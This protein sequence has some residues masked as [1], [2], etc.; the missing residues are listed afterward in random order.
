VNEST[1]KRIFPEILHQNGIKKIWIKL[2]TG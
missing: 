1:H 2:K